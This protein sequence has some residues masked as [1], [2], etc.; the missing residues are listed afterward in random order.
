M[1]DT[2]ILSGNEAIARGAWEGGVSF[3]AGYPGTPSSEILPALV[4]LGDAYTEWS[5]N[6]K[7]ALEAAAGASL[8]GARCLVTMKHV[9]LNVAA[10]PFFTLSYTGVNGAL[11]IVNADDPAM[12]SSQNEQDNRH[13]ARAAK[14]PMLEPS[15]SQEAK[16]FTVRALGLSEEFDTPVLLRITTRIAHSDGIVEMGKRVQLDR[17]CAPEKNPQK[18]VMVPAHARR[19]RVAMA[20]R[21][22]KLV[23]FAEETDLN[24]VEPG[25]REI[26]IISSGVAYQYAKE[27]A[28]EASFLKLGLTWPLPPRKLRE[29]AASVEKLYV[30]EELDPLI[31]QDVLALGIAVEDLPESLQIGEL[32]PERVAADLRGE[33]VAPAASELP[34]RPPVLCPGC[35]HRGVFMTLRKLKAFVTG[36][37]GCYTLGALPPL[38]SLHTCLCMGAGIG[39]AHGIE[40]A[41]HVGQASS[42]VKHVAVIGDSTFAHSGITGLVNIAYNGGSSVVVI[43]DNG[44]TAMTG[45]QDHPATGRTLS[46]RPGGRLD[47][48]GICRAAGIPNV[49]V[50]D[51]RDLAA[52]EAA[53]TKAMQ[54]QEPSVIIAQHPCVLLTRERA[55]PYQIDESACVQCGLCVRTGC[56]AISTRPTDDP[57]RPQPVIDAALCVGCGLCAQVCPEAAITTSM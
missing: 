25:S 22:R 37:I 52:T 36:D 17:E 39:Q 57:K 20:E 13:Y 42:P 51:P 14:V 9:G 26:G 56:P 4:E 38:Q 1:N 23:G 44:T 11:L 7:C 30:I 3:G 50:I 48:P 8:A 24:R 49:E 35:P 5:V 32:N 21:T 6:E 28:P 27:A 31:K 29:F 45:G 43:L 16:D 2:A 47:L 15:D 10:D 55:E 54:A 46:G 53:L 12:H 40:M 41:C 18:Y 33:D 34:P 19:R